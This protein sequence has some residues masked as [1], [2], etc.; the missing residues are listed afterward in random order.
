MGNQDKRVLIFREITLEPFNMFFVQIIGRLVQQKNIRFF[1]Q[2]LRQQNFC[3]L[4]AGKIR[5][6]PIK[7]QIQ[8]PQRPRN[9]LHLGVNHIKI[10]HG[11]HVLNFAQL[12]HESC[13]FL[14][15]RASQK[16]TDFI[17]TGFH[18]K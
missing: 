9:F 18:I 3:P 8:E 14:F 2:Q 1:Q 11:Q 16:I 6:L 5:N 17:H 13:H 10:M 15:A 12:F 4:A 7:P